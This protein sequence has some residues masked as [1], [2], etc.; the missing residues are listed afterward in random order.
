MLV[1]GARALKHGAYSPRLKAP[2]VEEVLAELVEEHPHEA[3]A[4][5]RA[6]EH[7]YE[8]EHFLRKQLLLVGSYVG[9]ADLGAVRRVPYTAEL[10]AD[11]GV[12]SPAGSSPRGS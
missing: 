9:R 1:A 5:L 12:R 7:V 11:A 10:I 3:V 2:R 4:N 6:L 8:L